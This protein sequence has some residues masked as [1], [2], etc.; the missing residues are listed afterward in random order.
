R[1]GRTRGAVK[2]LQRRAI[3]AILATVAVVLVVLALRD[4]TDRSLGTETDVGPAETPGPFDDGTT[5]DGDESGRAT[6]GPDT[7]T[8]DDGGTSIETAGDGPDRTGEVTTGDDNPS[9]S[10]P[11]GSG[12]TDPDPASD[13]ADATST[14][15]EPIRLADGTSRAAQLDTSGTPT[16]AATHG[17][18]IRCEAA[19]LSTAD[20]QRSPTRIHWGNSGVEAA[21]AG[22][23]IVDAG[24]VTC[25]GGI[26]DRSAYRMPT[27]VDADGR[28]VLPDLILV[29]YK[30]FGGPAF[31]RSTVEAIPAGLRLVADPSVTNSPERVGGAAADPDRWPDD[32]VRLQVSFP[33]CVA[34]D[35]TGDPVLGSLDDT[36]HLAYPGASGAAPN[37]CPASH[38]YRIPQLSYLVTY[39]VPWSSEWRLGTDP[40]R[41]GRLTAVTGSAVA[42]WA[43]A[44]MAD[45]LDCVRN[46]LE[47]CWF[48]QLGGSD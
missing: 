9:G 40:D 48:R 19:Y 14:S 13:D 35:G 1:T 20:G 39:D 42:G 32:R 45:V 28:V 22:P 3:N 46:E 8:V 21:E 41:V 31:D 12:S 18:R 26:S 17:V 33:S 27:V 47:G 38:P 10:G 29:E 36:T 37:D 43:T 5:T 7:L 30:A 34:V 11:A 16:A 2:G 25:E 6:P 24:D 44:S 15:T 4:L 23:G